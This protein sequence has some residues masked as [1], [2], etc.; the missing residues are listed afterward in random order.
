MNFRTREKNCTI[1]EKWEFG[2]FKLGLNLK[3][4][5]Y[6]NIEI[7]YTY[8]LQ[9]LSIGSIY[10]K[11]DDNSTIGFGYQLCHTTTRVEKH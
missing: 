7:L 10:V 11:D 1:I 2:N 3:M 8:R 4:T 9:S 5:I 6:N